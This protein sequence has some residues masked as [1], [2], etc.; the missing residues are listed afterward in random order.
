MWRLEISAG[1]Y[2]LVGVYTGGDR[3]RPRANGWVGVRAHAQGH[4]QAHA[5]VTRS[6]R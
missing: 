6:R 4:D 2:G 1:K 3:A 5:R